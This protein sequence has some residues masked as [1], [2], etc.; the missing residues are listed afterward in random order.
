VVVPSTYVPSALA[1]KV[2]LTLKEPEIDTPVQVR[3]SRPS[4]AGATVPFTVRHDD[5]TVHVPTTLP[6]QAVTFEQDNPLP[7]A[8]VVPPL[9][10]PPAPGWLP[11]L[12]EAHAPPMIM[13]AV[14]I[15][16]AADWSFIEGLLPKGDLLPAEI[17]ILGGV[18]FLVLFPESPRRITTDGQEGR[19][20]PRHR[21]SL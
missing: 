4:H 16:R 20:G 19:V 15:A 11:G 7:P 21:V 2:P 10:L 12:L 9:E 5:I 3:G 18:S 17:L 13:S 6:P 1:V 8:P 14:A